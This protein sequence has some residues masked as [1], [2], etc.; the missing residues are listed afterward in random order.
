MLKN[1]GITP[2]IQP[3]SNDGYWEAGHP[4]NEAVKALKDDKFGEWKRTGF[5]R[6]VH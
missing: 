1:K 6:N 4:R 2:S 3:R 5:I